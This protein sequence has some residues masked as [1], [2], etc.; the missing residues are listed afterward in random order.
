MKPETAFGSQAN[1]AVE[2]GVIG[3]GGRGTWLSDLMVEHTGARVSAL[4]DV[5]ADR[6]EGG[7][8]KFKVDASRLYRGFDSY[9]ELLASKVDAVLIESPPFFHPLHAAAAVAAGKHVYVAKP[10]AV[11]VPGCESFRQTGERAKGKVSFLVDFQTR[12]RPAFQEVAA[13][14]HRGEIG[15]PA[16]MHCYYHG[17]GG[18]GKPPDRWSAEEARL[19]LW[20]RDKVLS[21][22][23]IVEQNIHALDVAN[24]YLQ[25]HP[26]SATGSTAH[27]VRKNYGDCNDSFVV[28]FSY[29]NDVIMD[30]SSVQFIKGYYDIC[31]RLYGTTGTAD[32]HYGLGPRFQV[33]PRLDGYIAILG[34]NP[35][36]GADRDDTFTGGAI[37]NLKDFIQSVRTGNLLNNASESADSNLTSILGRTAAY[38]GGAV[39]WEEMMKLNTRLEAPIKIG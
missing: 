24:W 30:F 18:D 35:W 5:F 16:F 31:I 11:D 15:K 9:R 36:K 13:R 2:V 23:I 38:R 34:Q 6:L 1:S 7:Q 10:I 3:I 25:G 39:T 14:I 17:S 26:I 28:N 20:G 4:A 19:R 33:D 21:G 12:A 37:Q 29:A 8:K 22:D 27:T 32:T